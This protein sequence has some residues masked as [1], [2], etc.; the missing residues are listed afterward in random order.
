MRNKLAIFGLSLAAAIALG[1][2]AGSSDSGTASSGSG[3]ADAVEEGGTEKKEEKVAKIGDPARD[4]MFEFTV[5]KVKCGVSKVGNDFLNEKAQGQFCLVTVKVANIGKEPRTFT[6]SN[7]KAF[8]AD[9]AEYATNAVAGMYA[10]E[11]NETFL[12]EINPGNQVTGVLVFDIP[13]NATLAKI[14]LH[15]S[16]FSGGVTVELS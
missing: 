1:C 10:N 3:D 12:N 14:E 15:D 6:D 13:K 7:Q 2:G 5:Q 4:G 9:G 16:A 8:G 11:K